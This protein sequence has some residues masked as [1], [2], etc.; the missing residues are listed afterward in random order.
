MGVKTIIQVDKDTA[1]TLKN[2]K[3][4]KRESYDEIIKRLL[5][6]NKV[7]KSELSELKEKITNY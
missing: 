4:A 7:L 6:E 2:L 1:K 3:I 5:N